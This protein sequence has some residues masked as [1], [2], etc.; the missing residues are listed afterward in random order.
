MERIARVRTCRDWL[1]ESPDAAS[2]YEIARTHVGEYHAKEFEDAW[3]PMV[4]ASREP[5]TERLFMY[6]YAWCVYVSGFSASVISEK[7]R[8]LLVAH[9]IEAP[10][11]EY[12]EPSERN[13]ITDPG[14][15]FDP[16]FAHEIYRDVLGVFGNRRKA[17]AVQ[18]TRK[19]LLDQGWERLAET[20]VK[21]RDPATIRGK[22][23]YMGPALSRQL[24]RNLGNLDVAKPDV[25][26]ERLAERY[27]YGGTQEMCDDVAARAGVPAGR[28]DL[29]LWMACVDLG[30]TTA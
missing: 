4:A 7:F 29:T 5:V 27:G 8:D 17:R 28:V 15:L 10:D 9:R 19:I 23:P 24:A 2:A 26:L 16:E 21:D 11:G 20:A 25:H 18:E 1:N 12:V 14:E 30:S 13:V 3:G 6:E 22:F